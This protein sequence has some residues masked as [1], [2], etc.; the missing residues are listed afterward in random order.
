MTTNRYNL[1]FPEGQ[2]HPPAL[3]GNHCSGM[4]Q[5][6][7]Q[8]VLWTNGLGPLQGPCS[9]LFV[10]TG[11]CPFT[12]IFCFQV[13]NLLFIYL[14]IYTPDIIPPH[15]AHPPTVPYPLPPPHSCLHEDVPPHLT[16]KLPRASSLLRVRC[17]ISNWTQTRQSSTV[18]VR[19]LISAGVCCLFGGPVFE[20]SRLIE[21][22]G[23]PTIQPQGSAV[24]VHWLGANICIWLFQ[25]LVVSSK[26]WSC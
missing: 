21:T 14:F 12:W 10:Y 20:K 8:S 6:S 17:I 5:L 24:S 3:T 9:W 1:I 7:W 16:S 13:R 15:P 23:P 4:T 2:N 11:S 26:V 19:D 25:L 22:A 18:C